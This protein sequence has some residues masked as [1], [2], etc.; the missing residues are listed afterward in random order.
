[1]ENRHLLTG[2]TGT[3]D[4]LFRLFH[5]D[6]LFSAGFSDGWH[7]TRKALPNRNNRNNGQA[8]PVVPFG[9]PVFQCRAGLMISLGFRPSLGGCAGNVFFGRI[10]G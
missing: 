10:G 2:T 8:V 5:L 9:R 6:S 7:Y 3:N 4:S 1:M